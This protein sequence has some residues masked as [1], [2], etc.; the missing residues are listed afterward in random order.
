MGF[1]L[2]Y[3]VGSGIFINIGKT[4]GF[5]NHGGSWAF[6]H[7]DP[8]SGGCIDPGSEA[9]TSGAAARAGWDSLQYT[10]FLELGMV[11]QELVLTTINT[12]GVYYDGACPPPGREALLRTGWNASKPCLCE[13]RGKM[14]INCLGNAG[15]VVST[16]ARLAGGVPS[17][18]PWDVAAAAAAAAAQEE[19]LAL[20][21]EAASRLIDDPRAEERARKKVD[22]AAKAAASAASSVDE[23][24]RA[25]AKM[26]AK[27]EKAAF[28]AGGA[29][30][31]DAVNE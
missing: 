16:L 9:A 15:G 17:P 20:T 11:K 13:D 12:R 18:P 10:R 3:A 24:M 26:R 5:D 19:A 28:E 6:F 27:A 7:C 2:Y 29:A 30:R 14:E 8:R 22:A 23:A 21:R 25:A 31:G 4:L 1:W